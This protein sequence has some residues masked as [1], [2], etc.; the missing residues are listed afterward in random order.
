MLAIVLRVVGVPSAG[1]SGL[2]EIRNPIIYKFVAA[3]RNFPYTLFNFRV[4]IFVE[5]W[6]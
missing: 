1:W 5:I 3:E 4:Q 6:R 2:V